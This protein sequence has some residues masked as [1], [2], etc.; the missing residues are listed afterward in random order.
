M[1]A[2][3]TKSDELIVENK[4]IDQ[5]KLKPEEEYTHLEKNLLRLSKEFLSRKELKYNDNIIDTLKNMYCL[6]KA[7]EAEVKEELQETAAS[8]WQVLWDRIITAFNPNK[9]QE[10]KYVGLDGKIYTESDFR[11]WQQGYPLLILLRKKIKE[12]DFNPD[13]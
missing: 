9:E 11:H 12:G 10:Q 4:I 7:N 2:K 8:W 1:F 3:T 5:S 6:K 13:W